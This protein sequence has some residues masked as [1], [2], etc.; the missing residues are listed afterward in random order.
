MKEQ[1]RLALTSEYL[2]T[3]LERIETILSVLAKHDRTSFLADPLISSAVEFKLSRLAVELE[4]VSKYFRQS[5]PA[6]DWQTS[7]DFGNRLVDEYYAVSADGVWE[8]VQN[9]IPELKAQLMGIWPRLDDFVRAGLETLAQQEPTN[10]VQPA[11]Y[12]LD[13]IKVM[14]QQRKPQIQEQ[15]HIAELGIFGSYVRGEQTAASDLDILIERP[16]GLSLFQ[17]LELG[18]QLSDELGVKVDLVTKQ[19]LKPKVKERVLAEVVYV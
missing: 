2:E 19:G 4:R 17:L 16:E 10:Q 1:Q 14:L 3:V 9:T 12:R 18:D 8:F 11:A 5:C 13:D 7:I 6:V 15:Y